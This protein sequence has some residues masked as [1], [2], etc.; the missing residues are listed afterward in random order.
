MAGTVGGTTWGVAKGV[1]L[2]PVRVLDCS[3]SG[4]YSGVIAGIDWVANSPLRPAVANLSLGGVHLLR[5]MRRLP[6]R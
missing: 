6:E 1:K 2:I 4:A 3:G 5:W